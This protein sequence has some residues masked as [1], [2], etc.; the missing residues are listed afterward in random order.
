MI[1]NDSDRGGFSSTQAYRNLQARRPQSVVL[2]GCSL[3]EHGEWTKAFSSWFETHY[4]DLVTVRNTS[5]SGKNSAWALEHL[6][7]RVLDHKPDLVFIEFAYN[8]AH[9]KFD[10]SLEESE[11][12]LEKILQEL[13]A[14]NPEMTIVLQT[15]N[16]GWDAPNENRSASVRPQLLK[17][18]QQY[19]RIAEKH[20]LQLIDHTSIW[21]KLKTEDPETFQKFVPDGSHP[22]P[23]ASLQI[24]WPSIQTWLESYKSNT[25]PA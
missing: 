25:S 20:G 7:S 10:L 6:Q 3:T 5:G 22:S 19:H 17:Y 8:D 4:P 1:E 16:V 2:Y 14:Q 21:V 9:E 23:E 24:T 18:Y 12:N 13:R 11:G 15:M